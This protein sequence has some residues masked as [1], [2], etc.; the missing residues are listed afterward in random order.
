MKV[1]GFFD[2]DTSTLSFVVF[3]EVSK[4]AVIIDPVLGLDTRR[5]RVSAD[6]MDEI[7]AFVE[8][9]SL[10]VR[11]VVDT[12]AHADHL[13]GV[14]HLK[15]HYGAPTAIGEHITKVQE[16]FTGIYNLEDVPTDGRQWDRLLADGDTLDAGSFSLRAIHTPGHT[17][18]CLSYYIEGRD[19][20]PGLLFAGDTL[21]S[22]DYGTGRCDFPAGSA[23]D[24]Y[25][26]VTGA[27]FSLP[28][29]TRF[30]SGHDYPPGGREVLYESSVGE[31]K[32]NNVQLTA[33]TSREDFIAFREKRDAGLEAPRLILQSLQV[34]IDAGK[35]PAA[36]S[37]G[38]RYLRIPLGLLGS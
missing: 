3:D 9:E 11:W 16:L 38:R 1:E 13:S 23:S 27:I 4:D 14:Q 7:K 17:P 30:F 24:L 8:R 18:A 6:S 31:Q 26:S 2:D 15:E 21:F 34:N 10:T 35:L 29:D 22:P 5:W 28:D 32:R 36:E 25:T 12:H 37:N 20:V 33:E 19:G